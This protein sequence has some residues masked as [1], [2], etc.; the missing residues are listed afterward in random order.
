MDFTFGFF[1]IVSILSTLRD[2]G[3]SFQN[4]TMDDIAGPEL[5]QAVIFIHGIQKIQR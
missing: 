2:I 4:H 1:W 5:G 3:K